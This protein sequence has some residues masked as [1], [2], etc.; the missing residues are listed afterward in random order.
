MIAQQ[1]CPAETFILQ[2]YS[3]SSK[4]HNF[5][6]VFFRLPH[7]TKGRKGIEIILP[8][9]TATLSG[10]CTCPYAPCREHHYRFNNLVKKA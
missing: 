4:Q 6:F 10:R 3:F 9:L 1:F 7:K 2:S 8:Y 5:R